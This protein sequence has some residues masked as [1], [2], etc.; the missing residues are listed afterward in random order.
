MPT[1]RKFLTASTGA[2]LTPAAV[3]TENAP[4]QTPLF[5]FGLMAD[6]QFVDAEA[7]GSRHYRKSPGKLKAA[8]EKLNRHDLAFSFHLG[9][10][11]DRDFTSFDVVK[12]IVS[13]L[14]ARLHH[15][16]GNHDFDVEDEKK[17]Q[18]PQM[19]GLKKGYYSLVKLGI[20]FVVIDTTE[21]SPYRYADGTAPHQSAATELQ[22]LRKQGKAGAKPWNGRPGEEQMEW[23]KN[24]LEAAN[25]ADEKVIVLGHHPILPNE[26]HAVWNAEKMNE[27]LQSYSC[28]KLYLN[29]HN[30][31]GHYMDAKGL[32]YLTMDGMV[33]TADTNAFAI[34]S[35]FEDRLEISGRERQEDFVL[36][37]R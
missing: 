37:F 31:A 33:E 4:A 19:L 34:A 32:H 29:G 28:A 8:V 27:L 24:E 20:R 35:V 3:A 10:F 12:P 5:S 18:V 21:V 14:H 11:I 36:K 7:R 13:E 16:L 9:D 23:L 25:E 1:R 15:V 6:C 22:Q 26:S 2:A 17:P 30:H